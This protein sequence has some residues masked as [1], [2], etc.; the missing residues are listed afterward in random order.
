MI[1]YVCDGQGKRTDA[2]A[3]CIVCGMAVCRDHVIRE[4]LPVRERLHTGLGE[5]RRELPETL[6]RFLCPACYDAL[7]QTR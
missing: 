4:E 1:C 7:H 5:A 2:V 3:I 6:P